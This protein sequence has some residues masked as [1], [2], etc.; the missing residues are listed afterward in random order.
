MF[1]KNGQIENQCVHFIR[2]RVL[3]DHYDSWKDSKIPFLG[4]V[5]THCNQN[6]Q[7]NHCNCK[8]LSYKPR[9][10][11]RDSWPCDLDHCR[12]TLQVLEITCSLEATLHHVW[13]WT[14]HNSSNHGALCVW[15]LLCCMAI[16]IFDILTSRETKIVFQVISGI[17]NM[18][19]AA[20]LNI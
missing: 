9:Q 15:A 14:W 4:V 20:S 8:R 19:R 5:L 10:S 11:D 12:L 17:G 7:L 1:V 16:W 6:S 2:I 18:Q 13:H 3:L